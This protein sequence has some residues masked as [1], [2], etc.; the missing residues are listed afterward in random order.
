MGCPSEFVA[1]VLVSDG[2]GETGETGSD[3][4]EVKHRNLRRHTAGGMPVRNEIAIAMT[5]TVPRIRS[6]SDST[7]PCALAGSTGAPA[8]RPHETSGQKLNASL[9]V[10]GTRA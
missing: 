8:Q 9:V 10:F 4:N 6:I 2:R 3:Q 5:A 7:L 1:G